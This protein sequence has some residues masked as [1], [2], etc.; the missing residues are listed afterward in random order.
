M[1]NRRSFIKKSAIASAGLLL[2]NST[3]FSR[4]KSY[5]RILGANERIHVGLAGLGRRYGAFIE[6][7][8]KTNNQIH[9]SYL[10]DVMDKQISNA[11]KSVQAPLGYAPAQI[12]DYRKMMEDKNLDAVFIATPDHWHAPGSI[13]AMQNDKHVYVEKPC[14]HNMEEN[15]LL[16]DF[17]KRTGMVV[18]MGN[19]QR[20]SGHTIHIIRQI[21]N[22]LIGTPYKAVAFY[23]NN[24]GAVPNQKPAPIPTGLD[25]DLFQG[26]APRRAYTD[27]TWD[28][29]WHWYGWDFG[30]AEAGN[31][32]TH[33]LDVAR[34][35]LQVDFPLSVRVDAGKFH[36]L[37]DGWT[38]Y[39]TMLAEFKFDGNK[40]IQW[41]GKSRNGLFTYGSD[42]GVLIYGS[43]GSVFVNREKYIVYDRSGK[44]I[45]ES[46]QKSNEAGNAL[47]GGGDMTTLHV[48]NFFDAIRGKAALNAPIEDASVSMAMVHYSNIAYRIG[49]SFKITKDGKMQNPEAMKLWT[50]E[51][52]P[53]WQL[54]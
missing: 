52:E 25:W 29:N 39:D 43:E 31:N 44:M 20:S 18:Q 1:N 42:R 22:G 21:H 7:I 40:T 49:Q 54:K 19:Q 8:A 33:E 26:P 10:C 51:Y 27:N 41:D 12:K 46:T 53:G 32:G 4:A 23:N 30:T 15:E 36:F 3:L 6:P 2:A 11:L 17:Q 28:Y 5:K 9:L 38:M 37:E 14:S 16:V 34:W 13:M 45:E 50:R 24:R 48:E 35:A 47:G